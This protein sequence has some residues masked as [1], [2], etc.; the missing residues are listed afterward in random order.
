MRH[1]KTYRKLSRQRHHYRAL[2]RN[3]ALSLFEH[4]RIKTTMP[5]AKEARRF[6]EK[7]VTLGKR[8]RLHDRR[9]AMALMGNKMVHRA[10]NK[11]EDLVGKVFGE[12]AERYK[13]R[14]GGYTR[15]IRLAR[16]RAGDAA[17][18]VLFE[19]VDAPESKLFKTSSED[20]EGT[21]KKKKS[22]KAKSEPE[23]T[24]QA[25]SA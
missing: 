20:M 13:D 11:K 21:P 19:L 3:M 7:I 12:L 25:Q 14:A 24:E 2:M 22:K 6:V 5:K 16:E 23:E 9:R 15:I 10:D 18:M 4:E 17:T 1:S 8:G